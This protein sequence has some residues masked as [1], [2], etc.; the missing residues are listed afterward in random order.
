M[1]T[2]IDPLLQQLAQKDFLTYQHSVAVA[3]YMKKF[4]TKLGL[5]DDH[6]SDCELLGAIHDITKLSI[7]DEV[8]K[9]LQAGQTLEGT[10]RNQLH[11]TPD[12]IFE[13]VDANLLSGNVQAAIAHFNCRYDG[14]GVPA[15]AGENIHVMAR[16]LKIC[17][18]FDFLTR[19]RAGQKPL[20]PEDCRKVLSNNAGSL[21][22]PMLIEVFNDI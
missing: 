18:Y 3:D 11:C 13:F 8:F 16:M 14:K 17:D 1:S 22:D 12:K 15:D 5:E 7:S 19:H 21:F 9:K 2:A 4:A 6:C 10:E 20:T